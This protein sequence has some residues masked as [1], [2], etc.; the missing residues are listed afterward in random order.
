MSLAP[1]EGQG[2]ARGLLPA[3]QPWLKSVSPPRK[4]PFPAAAPGLRLGWG[5]GV[6]EDSRHERVVHD[7]A[8]Y[9]VKGFS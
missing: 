2:R 7:T 6:R 1:A 3:A 8:F 5:W 9:N 4:G